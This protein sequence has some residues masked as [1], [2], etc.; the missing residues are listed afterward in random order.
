MKIAVTGGTGFVGSHL[1][2]ALTAGGHEVV[3]L[4]RGVDGREQAERVHALPGVTFRAVDVADPGSIRDALAGCDAVAHCAGI[5]RE[6]GAQ[7]YDAVHVEGTRNLVAAAEAAGVARF[8]LV[9]FLRARPDCGS[10]YHESKW[11]AEE[12]V[13]AST[14]EWTIVKP[15]MMF[16]RGDHMLDHLSRALHTFPVY[17]GIGSRRVRPLAVGDLVRVMVAV[18]V[19]GRLTRQT[20]ALTGPDEMT[21]DDAVRAVAREIDRHPLVVRA[22]LAFHW[23]LAWVSEKLMVIPLVSAA[24]VRILSEEVVAPTRAPDALP[25]DLVPTEPFSART[26]RAGLPAPARFGRADLRCRSFAVARSS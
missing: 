25:A 4:A 7:T 23:V 21:F 1:A 19:D 12:I 3:L 14:L 13:R 26:I 11:A 20:V 22:P 9:S 16:G 15:G 24:Q 18:L 17:V 10:P 5:N 8:V 6:I 2:E